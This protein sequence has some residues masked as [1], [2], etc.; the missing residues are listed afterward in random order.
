MQNCLVGVFRRY[1]MPE[2]I[3]VD[4]GSPWGSD[5]EHRHTRL[6][7]WLLRLGVVVI[8]GRAYHPQ[9]QGKVERFHR[10]LQ[11]EVLR[12]KRFRDVSECQAC[13][14]K[15]RDVYNWDRPHDALGLRVP[16]DVYH[17]SVT[18]L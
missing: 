3:L 11:A 12:H 13:F 17:P 16:G 8:H 6:T 4:N 10:T 14:S 1:G 7:V 18:L 15:W 9:T 2:R 5:E